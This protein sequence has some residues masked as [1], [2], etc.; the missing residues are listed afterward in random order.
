MQSM[1]ESKK[2]QALYFT[3]FIGEFIFYSLLTIYLKDN[4]F[5]GTEVGTLLSFSPFI[6]AFSQPLWATI[7]KGKSR[8]ILIL[9]AGIIIIVLEFVL[10]YS[11]TFTFLAIIMVLYSII[12]APLTPSLDAM[13][14]VYC[15]ENKKDYSSF[16]AFGSIGFI[17]AMLVGSYLYGKVHFIYLVIISSVF[18][19]LFIA[20][21]I[22]IK[23]LD[24]DS[25]KEKNHDYK[26]LFKNKEF[27]KFLIA[28]ILCFATLMLNN[29]YDILYL[30]Y[31][32]LNTALFGVTTLIR[33]GFETLALML[34]RKAKT[35][36]YKLFFVLMPFLMIIQSLIYYF[37]A[38]VY[39]LFI[40]VIF[41]GFASGIVIFLNNKYIA[42]IVRPRNITVATYITVMVQNVF[43]AVYLLLGGMV[44]DY[45]G[46][47]YIYLFTAVIFVIAIVFLSIFFKKNPEIKE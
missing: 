35:A 20:V 43:I 26:Q 47:K 29:A 39:T 8:K 12:R 21:T 18:F 7:D 31:R 36:L 16:R 14:T 38:P 9:C 33:V 2:Y 22:F 34:L 6:L 41:S 1:H 23:P 27:I 32:G 45:I 4:G 10:T 17:V 19:T 28:Q 5:N 46:I 37:E 25:D 42:R 13:T 30:D 24:I 44:I 3:R 11:K 40:V 15:V